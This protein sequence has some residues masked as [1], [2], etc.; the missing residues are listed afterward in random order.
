MLVVAVQRDDRIHDVAVEQE[1]DGLLGLLPRAIAAIQDEERLSGRALVGG[2]EGLFQIL[3]TAGN[4]LAEL[5]GHGSTRHEDHEAVRPP[6]RGKVGAKQSDVVDTGQAAGRV[7]MVH[8]GQVRMGEERIDVLARPAGAAH[9]A[10]VR[11][12]LAPEAFSGADVMAVRV[13]QD[14]DRQ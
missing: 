12:L 4:E 3:W 5:G 10:D 7:R 14:R 8:E 13:C 6:F 2:V 9:V 1:E 11:V